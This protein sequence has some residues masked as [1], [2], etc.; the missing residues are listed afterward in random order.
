VYNAAV[1]LSVKPQART[2]ITV[3]EL[4]RRVKDLLEGQSELAGIWVRGEASNVRL[5]GA[6]HLYFTLK[7]ASAQLRCAYF[8][9]GRGKRQPPAD[10]ELLL[11]HGDVRVYERAGEYQ[12]V[13]DDFVRAGVGDLA[14]QFEALKQRLAAEGLFDEERKAPLPFL[15]RRVALVTGSATA[16]LR[17]VLNVLGRRAPYLEAVLFP[18][19]VQGETAPAELIAALAAADACPEVELILLVRGGGSL[20]DLWCFNDETLAR[21]IAVTQRPVITGVG[22]EIDFTIADFVADRRAPTPSAAAELAAPD[23]AQL[24][25]QLAG[26]RSRLARGA[27]QGPDAARERLARLFDHRL[28]RDVA[29]ALEERTQDLDGLAGG[30]AQRAAIAAGLD[31]AGGALPLLQQLAGPLARALAEYG[32]SLPRKVE[33]LPRALRLRLGEIEAQLKAGQATLLARDPAAP[34][35]LGFALVWDSLSGQLVRDPAQLAADAQLR[36]EVREG[37][38]TARRD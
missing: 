8:G 15:P 19:A 10:G 9:F 3:S 27:G 26:L 1:Q 2:E 32:Y 16:A 25:Q 17:D 37:E 23:G 38:F 18:A 31:G 6:G 20:E 11:V 24:A 14:A 36:I 30:L 33:A 34:K 21:A 29:G 28:L 5:A 4:T 7:D 35:K 13:A 12:L 22:H